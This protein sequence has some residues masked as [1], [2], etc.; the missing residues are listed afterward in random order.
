MSRLDRIEICHAPPQKLSGK[1]ISKH[2]KMRP[3]ERLRLTDINRNK[4]FQ[5]VGSVGNRNASPSP[6][7]LGEFL[8]IRIANQ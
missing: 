2:E 5:T 1:R 4:I 6:L 8:V 3:N 7:N